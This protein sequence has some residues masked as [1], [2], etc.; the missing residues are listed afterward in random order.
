MTT[1]QQ[2][3]KV[4]SPNRALWLLLVASFSVVLLLWA[5][6]WWYLTTCYSAFTSWGERGS[7][8]DMFGAVNSLFAALALAFVII[9]LYLQIRSI[10]EARRNAEEEKFQDI[11]FR[12][13]DLQQNVLAGIERFRMV[14]GTP[15]RLSGRRVFS[16]FYD[17]LARQFKASYKAKPH[18]D[19]LLLIN[20]SYLA[21]YEHE[22]SNVGHYFRA[23]Y[24]IVKFID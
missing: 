3:P 16:S 10:R 18:E 7:F 23:L 17:E 21:F 12:L 20:K 9:T 4:K 6:S 19:Q 11:F 24:N 22:Q 13:L 14:N 8:G 1:E 15:I 5:G 2:V